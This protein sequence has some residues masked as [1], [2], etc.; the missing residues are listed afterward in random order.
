MT[1]AAAATVPSLA[2]KPSALETLSVLLFFVAIALLS[3]RIGEALGSASVWWVLAMLA[4]GY[5]A[6]DAFSGLVHWMFDTWGSPETP[7]LGKAFIVP[8][9]VHHS[10][11]EDIT[12]HGFI[13]T[14]GHNCLVS[15][16]VLV[17]AFFLPRGVAWADAG[18]AFVTALCL[19]VFCTNQF[20]KWAHAE[21]RSPIVAWLQSKGIILS[22]EH[23]AVHHSAPYSEHYCITTGW[24][25][26]PLQTIRF[27]RALEWA[28]DEGS[29][30]PSRARTTSRRPSRPR[31]PPSRASSPAWAG[32]VRATA[33]GLSLAFPAVLPRLE[34]LRLARVALAELV[35]RVL[36]V[37]ARGAGLSR[38]GHGVRLL[39]A[40]G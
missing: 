6:A 28:I 23:H 39:T 18:L 36:G 3:A 19:G 8:F 27:F 17:A 21:K 2:R 34:A 26:R 37:D 16:P 35:V 20:H 12:R 7:V 33:L 14:N 4:L 38:V 15:L 11:P 40:G 30:A 29:P 9:R 32:A 25:N 13:A 24:M 1:P 22:P 5:L 31:L 10:D